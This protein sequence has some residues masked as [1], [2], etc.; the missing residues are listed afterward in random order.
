MG[1][2]RDQGPQPRH[3]AYGLTDVRLPQ[4]RQQR[5][6]RQPGCLCLAA[7]VAV[8]AARCIAWVRP[9]GG[10]GG[11][12]GNLSREVSARGRGRPSGS[13]RPARRGLYRQA[14][15]MYFCTK[16]ARGHTRNA[17]TGMPP[18]P[19]WPRCAVVQPR[20]AQVRWRLVT[21]AG[22]PS[23]RGNKMNCWKQVGGAN[24]GKP[25]S[26]GEQNTRVVG[27]SSRR[28]RRLP[29][30]QG[31]ERPRRQTGRSGWCGRP[32]P[33]SASPSSCPPPSQLQAGT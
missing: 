9:D 13:T 30:P 15:V 33:Q 24:K 27:L 4:Q 17:L 3:H 10:G 8:A 28:R 16:S 7:D 14:H 12:G 6:Q 1:C 20:A 5:Q 32:S 19:S 11:G 22:S 2:T 29:L 31:Q 18:A 23:R 25:G 21:R 26:R